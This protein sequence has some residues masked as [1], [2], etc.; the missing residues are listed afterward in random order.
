MI[1]VTGAALMMLGLVGCE[2]PA[3]KAKDGPVPVKLVTVDRGDDG[4]RRYPG[5]VM[6]TERSQLAFRVSGQLVELPVKD[7]Q[8]VEEGQLLARLDPRDFQNELD[9]SQ[10]DAELAEKNYQRGRVL[11]ERGVI[12]ES[13]LDELLSRYHQARA[14]FKL[15]RD[16]LSYTRLLAPYD[17]VV[18]S[19]EQENHQFVQ[20]QEPVMNLQ[21]SATIDV[22]FS[23]SQS[24]I[25]RMAPLDRTFRAEV[26]F[27]ALPEQRFPAV[28]REHEAR[29]GSTQAYSVVVTLPTPEVLAVLPGMSAEVRVDEEQLNGPKRPR[30]RVP[31]G[32]IFNQDGKEGARVWR[33][34]PEAGTVHAET[35]TLGAVTGSGVEIVK[36]LEPGD[37]VVSAGVHR[38]E[39]GQAVRELT[40]ERGL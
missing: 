22:R 18:A 29:T 10:A 24:F 5:R 1:G 32:A 13:E 14:A 6:A 15:A 31:V 12:A 2:E 38:L 34:D 16:N 30:A 28:Y 17:G 27:P 40:R 39:E 36:G 21:S 8:R 11:A 9:R 33:L 3:P 7:G 37:R 23:V 19:T 4:G 35:V 25:S 20:A 26:I